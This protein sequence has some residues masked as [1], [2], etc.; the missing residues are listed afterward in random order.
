MQATDGSCES[1]V[2]NTSNNNAQDSREPRKANATNAPQEKTP[3]EKT[4]PENHSPDTNDT[5]SSLL[6]STTPPPPQSIEV[7]TAQRGEGKG[8]RKQ[9]KMAATDDKKTSPEMGSRRHE[10]NP[11]SCHPTSSHHTAGGSTSPEERNAQR[12]V[13][14]SA[15]GSTSPGEYNSAT[16]RRHSAGGSTSTRE[17]NPATRHPAGGSTS[18]AGN[19]DHL[20]KS[21]NGE[22]NISKEQATSQTEA[23]TANN[24]NP[25]AKQK[26]KS[27]WTLQEQP[28]TNTTLKATSSPPQKGRALIL[29]E[30]PEA[31]GAELNKMLRMRGYTVTSVGDCRTDPTTINAKWCRNTLPAL[32]RNTDIVFTSPP[33]S[34]YSQLQKP[35]NAKQRKTLKTK[36]K[37]LLN[38]LL[39]PLMKALIPYI[40]RG[41]CVLWEQPEGTSFWKTPEWI[42][43]Y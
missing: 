15:G 4:T 1:H 43:F 41:G 10:D 24:S 39:K 5:S 26:K 40:A 37:R 34:A 25:T 14:H 30:G 29:C 19:A 11:P 42:K 23:Q 8:A 2:T 27:N 22:N 32:L 38:D 18:P 36:R 31:G 21:R 35:R 28:T 20:E 33:C 6:P 12:S 17:D 7:N 13:C 16:S 9:G 3:G